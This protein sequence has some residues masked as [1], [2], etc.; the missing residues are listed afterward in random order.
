LVLDST[1]N[2][3]QEVK[4]FKQTSDDPYNRHHYK[5]IL[6]NGREIVFEDY[7]EVQAA[8]LQTPNQFL[9]HIE[10]LDIKQK[11]RGFK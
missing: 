6:S 11:S 8:W 3:K 9:S 4:T 1:D 7:M 5:L 10:V 2:D